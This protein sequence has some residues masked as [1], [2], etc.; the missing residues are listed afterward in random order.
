MQTLSHVAEFLI[1]TV[2]VKAIIGHYLAER[3]VKYSKV[4]FATTERKTAIWLHYNSRAAGMGHENDNVITCGQDK[5]NVFN[6]V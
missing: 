3:I 5:C 2:G 4:W 1:F 6:M